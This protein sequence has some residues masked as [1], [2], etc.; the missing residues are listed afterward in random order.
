MECNISK[1]LLKL[2]LNAQYI[3]YFLWT[4]LFLELR[5]YQ[6]PGKRP[7][8]GVCFTSDIRA[9]WNRL[10]IKMW[11]I[12]NGFSCIGQKWVSV[13]NQKHFR[14]WALIGICIFILKLLEKSS[15]EILWVKSINK[16]SPSGWGGQTLANTYNKLSIKRNFCVSYILGVLQIFQKPKIS[17]KNEKSQFSKIFYRQ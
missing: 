4:Y 10:F 6:S 17:K 2:F 15:M 11:A 8:I 12:T 5:S 9:V 13:P 14:S 1:T 7:W 3:T 16:D